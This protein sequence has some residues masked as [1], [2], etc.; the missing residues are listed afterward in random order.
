MGGQGEEGDLLQ[1]VPLFPLAAGGKKMGRL[2]E[3]AHF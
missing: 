3:A 2:R 1:K